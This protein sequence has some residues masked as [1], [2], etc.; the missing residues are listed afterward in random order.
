MKDDL[1]G[2]LGGS[3][4]NVGPS[5]DPRKYKTIHCS[6]CN[7]IQ[8]VNQYVLKRVSGMELGQGAKDMMIP[9]NVLVC[10]KCG[11]IL[12]DDIKGYKLEEDLGLKVDGDSQTSNDE[13][14]KTSLII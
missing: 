7:S 13:K 4:P 3:V 6:K 8:F 9:L 12:D 10:A 2:L 5:A 1:V 11:A 14:S